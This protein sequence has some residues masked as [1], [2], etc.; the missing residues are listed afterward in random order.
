[1]KII[2]YTAFRLLTFRINPEEILSFNNKHLVLGIACTW[3]VG[4][5]R[6]WDHENAKSL[7]HIFG[8]FDKKGLKKQILCP[9][10]IN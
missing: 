2:F 10:Q 6:Y 3:L 4:I 1:L 7:Q 5:G 9:S 8:I